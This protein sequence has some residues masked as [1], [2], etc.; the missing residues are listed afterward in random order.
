MKKRYYLRLWTLVCLLCLVNRAE[1]YA[2]SFVSEGQQSSDAYWFFSS[3]EIVRMRESARTEW[4]EQ[5]LRGMQRNVEERM[6][7]NM[8]VP[9]LEAGHGHFYVCPIHNV[10][11]TF[12]WD[13]PTAHYCA[14]CNKEYRGVSRYNWGWVN[15]VHAANQGF[16]M[17]CMYLY[18][19]T[20]K[21]CYARYI[22]DMLLDYANMYPG[23]MVHDAWRKPSEAHSGKMFGQSLDE[24]VWFSYAAR[25]YVAVR[26]TLT[27][28][29][30]QKIEL[31]LF[32][33][34]ADLLLRRRD[35]GNWQ[36]WHNCGLVA[37]GIAL[38]DDHL[39]SVALD[40]AQCGYYTL[41]AKHV[42]SDGWWNE[43][44]PIYH[45]YPL[46]AIMMTADAVR[47]RNID[48][49]DN[50]LYNM[51]ASPVRGV[52]ADLTFPAHNDGWYGESL[53]AQSGLY[54]VAY[55]RFGDPLFRNVL[56][57]CYRFVSRGSGYALLNPETI[58]P[59]SQPLKQMSYCFSDAGFALLRS[60]NA[61]VV[62]KY[63][64]HG[65]GHGHPD[66]LSISLHDGKREL[67][68]DFGTSA[69]GAP[70]YTR[71]YRR[72]LAHNTV[73][74]DGQDQA[75]TTGKLITFEAHCNG[76]T[77]KACADSAYRDVKMCRTLKLAGMKLTDQFVCQSVKSH[78]YDYVLLFNSRPQLGGRKGKSV[79]FSSAPYNC[80]QN[81][82]RFVFNSDFTISVDGAEIRM[83]VSAPVEVFVGEASGIPP[84]N[85]G[86]KTI[87]GSENR[88]VLK[89][90]PVIIR[91]KE[92]RSVTF[93][94]QWEIM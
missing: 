23:Y 8:E 10:T 64:P 70:D 52:Y 39:I 35:S 42:Y 56:A 67:L 2:L 84:T 94:A 50:Q 11:F 29:Q 90:Y 75:A 60:E 88:P 86:V 41:M 78:C 63:G 54:E 68:S 85:P 44:S 89:S 49:Y 36:V 57:Q 33:Q 65:G 87:F 25:A 3:D 16:L 80:I 76:G 38:R 32:R 47:C 58:A 82:N 5:I 31:N 15:F 83:K 13:Y 18:L 53:V 46:A 73:T 91:V 77:I 30:R 9:T 19:A 27:E 72:T 69:Y 34:A 81:V 93:E 17:N 48:L 37:L 62:M 6:T 21:I 26:E 59:A 7:H 55:A 51:L 20:N 66:K 45:F 4:G 1:G 79:T 40:D 61:T 92:Q 22:R 71:W 14:A 43:G 12:R 24:A 28:A 74:V